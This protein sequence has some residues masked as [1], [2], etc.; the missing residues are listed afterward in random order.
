MREDRHEH[1]SSSLE[2]IGS[3]FG[4]AAFILVLFYWLGPPFI[5]CTG[6]IALS[7]LIKALIRQ[8]DPE[9]PSRLRRMELGVLQ[10]LKKGVT[11]FAVA[12][13]CVCLFLIF[14]WSFPAALDAT[15]LGDFQLWLYDLTERLKS[16]SSLGRAALLMGAA[17]LLSITLN[18]LRP[19]VVVA[20]LRKGWSR[21]TGIL[22]AVVT[23]GFVTPQALGSEIE[24]TSAGLRARISADLGAIRAAR[25][26]Q[27]ALQWLGA[28]LIERGEEAQRWRNYFL[29]SHQRCEAYSQGYS[30]AYPT[31][32]AAPVCSEEAAAGGIV[33]R[34]PGEPEAIAWLADFADA[35]HEPVR[36]RLL[37]AESKHGL[38]DIRPLL[39]RG[40]AAKSEAERARDGVRSIVVKAAGEL[41]GI[42]ETNAMLD[43]IVNAWKNA[44]MSQLVDETASRASA[45][46]RLSRM[47]LPGAAK[48]LV[49]L[50]A[51][52]LEIQA[53]AEDVLGVRSAENDGY[54]AGQAQSWHDSAAR[55]AAPISGSTPG[56]QRPNRSGRR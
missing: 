7:F 43:A 1:A 23:F 33:R 10:D 35:V 22:L 25:Q 4:F 17:I 3:R 29:G 12:S 50:G 34:N 49:D 38:A 39:R 41:L 46:I 2:E 26:E 18:S 8:I 21:A 11:G 31:R 27:A 5:V 52:G 6:A 16:Y 15:A 28:I 45:W 44:A 56:P 37:L 36:D 30:S 9:S 20:Q 24:R 47:P 14:C 40:G 19:I 42:P 54:R 53:P 51:E 48:R 55:S 32:A 13:A